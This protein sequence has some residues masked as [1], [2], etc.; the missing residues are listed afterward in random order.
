MFSDNT[1]KSMQHH[2]Q[3]F[4]SWKMHQI[5]QYIHCLVTLWGAFM[6]MQKLSESKGNLALDNET[7]LL[8]CSNAD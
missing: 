6:V 4:L 3:E 2:D 7:P 8:K 1:A 5:Q